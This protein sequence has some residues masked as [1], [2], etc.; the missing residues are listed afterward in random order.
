MGMTGNLA[1]EER[2]AWLRARLE[3]DGRV[4]IADAATD[5][6][7]SDMTIRRDLQELEALGL[8]RR[9]RGGAVAV[10][11]L[12][13]LE[14]SRSRSKAKARIASKLLPMIAEVGAIG[15]DASTTVGRV[16]AMIDFARDLTVVTNGMETFQTLHGRPGVTP[17]LTG[18]RL[19]ARTGSL[20]GPL[21]VVAA[22]HLLLAGFL[23]SAAAVDPEVGP[24]EA[25]IEDAEIKRS[26]AAVSD[27]VVLA[28]DSSKLGA[29]AMAV[30]VGWEGIG[31]LVT[32]LDPG[33]ARLDP[34]RE[35]VAVL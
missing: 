26:L 19:D 28:V 1:T 10:G 2:I 22:G 25:S 24:S 32:D 7:V 17:L 23:M 33:D 6:G 4:R 34:Y 5:L 20:V 9:V 21:A 15:M 3:L 14:R 18:G 29:R 13:A 16:A 27:V 35:H 30:S 11:P 12:A 31:T 8:A